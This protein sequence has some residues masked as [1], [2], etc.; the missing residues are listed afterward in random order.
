MRY[1]TRLLSGYAGP[2]QGEFSNR[3]DTA[4]RMAGLATAL[5]YGTFIVWLYG[6]Q[7]QT[8][9]EVTG[10]VAATVGAYQVD[11]AHFEEGRRFFHADRFAAARA[12]FDRADP[13]KRDATT[14]FYIAYSY[15][16]QGW[17]R[18]QS[19]DA[20]YKL[21]LEALDRAVKASS[22]GRVTAD[23][24]N[25]AITNSDELRAELEAGRRVDASDFNPMRV[26]RRRK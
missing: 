18:L 22:D 13:A 11:P 21:G 14:Q 25:L 24:A 16:R 10:G 19:D 23:D 2:V 20:L 3:H 26:L 12:A 7:P 1:T 17:G 9:A 5:L 4:V 8:V 15:Y 6:Q